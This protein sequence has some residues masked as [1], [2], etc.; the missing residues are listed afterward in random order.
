MAC[1]ARLTMM[2]AAIT[3]GVVRV[4]FKSVGI[5][6]IRKKKVGRKEKKEQ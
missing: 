6:P 2:A 1:M 4:V 5:H 3:V